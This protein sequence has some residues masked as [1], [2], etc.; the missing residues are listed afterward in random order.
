MFKVLVFIIKREI[1]YRRTE[2]LKKIQGKAK[3]M[4]IKYFK[5]KI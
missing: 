2:D 4:E 3:I 1:I 5:W